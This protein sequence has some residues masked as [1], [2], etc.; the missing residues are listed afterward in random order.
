MKLPNEGQLISRRAL[1][2]STA[3]GFG[4]LGLTALLSEGSGLWGQTAS[5]NPLAPKTPH[6]TPRAKRVIFLFMHGGPSGIDTFDPKPRLIRDDG[7]PLPFKRPLSFADEKVG[8]L[9]RSPWE[10]KRYG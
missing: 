4:M 6:H 2:R 3:S 10:F 7:K 1:L 9:M 5:S 8:G